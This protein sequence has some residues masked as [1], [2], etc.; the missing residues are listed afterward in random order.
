MG[1]HR[2]VRSDEEINDLLNEAALNVDAGT[3]KFPGMSYEEGVQAAI[4]WLTGADDS[5]PMSND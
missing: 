3:P 1:L 4:N 5:N 2:I